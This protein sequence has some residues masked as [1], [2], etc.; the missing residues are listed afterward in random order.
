M[1]N[2]ISK[3]HLYLENN[4]PFFP[5]RNPMDSNTSGWLVTGPDRLPGDYGFLII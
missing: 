4:I 3:Y 2:I 5:T 1:K